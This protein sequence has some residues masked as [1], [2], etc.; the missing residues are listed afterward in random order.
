MK[1]SRFSDAPWANG[2]PRG[3]NKQFEPRGLLGSP[4]RRLLADGED[5]GA[6]HRRALALV[7]GLVPGRVER[8]EGVTGRLGAR[9][10]GPVRRARLVLLVVQLE[11]R[12]VIAVGLADARAEEADATE[13][14]HDDRGLL[15]LAHYLSISRVDTIRDGPA[16]DS[17]QHK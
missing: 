9:H 5:L 15:V 17:H 3:S 8:E 2:R 11:P 13:H 6:G 4:D 14:G 10:V 16:T 1:A 7:V 12:V